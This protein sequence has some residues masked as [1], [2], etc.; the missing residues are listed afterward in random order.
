MTTGQRKISNGSNK[1]QKIDDERQ[2][3]D[4]GR[5]KTKQEVEKLRNNTRTTS[6]PRK[7]DSPTSSTRP[8]CR[9]FR[10]YIHTQRGPETYSHREYPDLKLFLPHCQLKG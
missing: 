3:T 5:R 6:K 7:H 8:T 1:K 10:Q 2:D 4:N 9:V